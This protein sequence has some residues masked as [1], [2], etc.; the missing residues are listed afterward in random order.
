MSTCADCTARV[1]EL[2]G[3]P[4]VLG[5]VSAADLAVRDEPVPETILAG[6][7]RAVARERRRRRFLVSGLGG[8]AAA[9]VL[10]LAVVLSTGSTGGSHPQPRAQQMVATVSTPVSATAVV[11]SVTWG[12]EIDLV[13]HYASGYPSTATYSLVVVDRAGAQHDA[14]SWTLAPER[15]TTFTGGTAVRRDQIAKIEIVSGQ[16]PI[17]Q[18]SL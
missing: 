8:L 10:A 2:R 15:A 14:G 13:C 7:L 12:T 11:K 4:R 9:C 18:L 1:A 17:L 3:M 6:L 5:M 16:T